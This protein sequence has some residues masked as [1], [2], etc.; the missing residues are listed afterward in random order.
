MVTTVAKV[1]DRLP[2]SEKA[3]CAILAGNYAK[4]SAVDYFG[5]DLGLPPAICG[6]NNYWI[7]GPHDYTGEVTISIG[8]GEEFLSEIFQSVELAAVT[9]HPYAMAW[10]TNQPVFVCRKPVSPLK[11]LWP[12]FKGYS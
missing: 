5:P 1:Y 9:S 2:E 11:K 12:R 8:F 3:G 7:W 6:H 4:A 10:E